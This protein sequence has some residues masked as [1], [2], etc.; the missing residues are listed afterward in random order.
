MCM[1][2]SY[3]TTWPAQVSYGIPIST[4]METFITFSKEL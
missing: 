3:G 4:V 2:V 1:H